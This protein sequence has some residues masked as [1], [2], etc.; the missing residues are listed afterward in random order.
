MIN[1]TQNQIDKIQIDEGLIYVN[2]GELD[3]YLLGPTRGGGEFVATQEIRD[4]E[5]DGKK[6]KTKGLQV[7]GDIGAMLKITTLMCSQDALAMAL[8]GAVTSNSVLQV[9]TATVSGTVSTAGDAKVIVTAAGVTGSP[10]SFDVAVALND[11]AAQAAGKIKTALGLNAALIAVYDIGGTG[12]TVTLTKK[13]AGDNDN[14]LNILVTN[15]TS[16]GL[17]TVTNSVNTVKGAVSVIKSANPGIIASSNYLKNVTM[18]AKL[19][20]GTYKQ[21]SIYNAMQ[22]GDFTFAAKPKAENEHAL[23]LIAHHDPTDSLADL[24]EIKEVSSI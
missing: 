22:E 13:V 24:Y 7:L 1:L 12:A 16:V 19:V 6:G 3:E 18:F 2:Y 8:P 17:A 20:D 4:I 23:E 10:L 21:I 9:E 15:G 5:Y 14:T 11:T